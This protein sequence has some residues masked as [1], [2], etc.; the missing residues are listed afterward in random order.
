M[1]QNKA[2]YQEEAHNLLTTPLRAP[3]DSPTYYKAVAEAGVVTRCEIEVIDREMMGVLFIVETWGGGGGGI[4]SH[5]IPMRA[6]SWFRTARTGSKELATKY[7]DFEVGTFNAADGGVTETRVGI[8]VRLRGLHD[9][10]IVAHTAVVTKPEEDHCR[11]S[12]QGY[13]SGTVALEPG[14]EENSEEGVLPTPDD[15][16]GLRKAV[17]RISKASRT[18]ASGDREGA[19]DL[20]W[21]L[22]WILIGEARDGGAWAWAWAT[23]WRGC[24]WGEM[25]GGK[26][27][28]RRLAACL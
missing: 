19:C 6:C 7:Y 25:M 5:S 4:V 23:G 9:T 21:E 17:L 15:A 14:M 10:K 1:W 13:Q 26:G 11:R 8:S 22:V 2:P 18:H 3:A 28:R 27:R 24:R 20:V 12:G 16:A